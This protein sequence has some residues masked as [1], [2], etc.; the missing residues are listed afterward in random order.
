[1][2]SKQMK[3]EKKKRLKQKQKEITLKNKELRKNNVEVLSSDNDKNNLSDNNKDRMELLDLHK[4]ELPD[5]DDIVA[6]TGPRGYVL[7]ALNKMVYELNN[8]TISDEDIQGIA[9]LL[10]EL[11]EKPNTMYKQLLKIANIKDNDPR[12][13]SKT[14][15]KANLNMTERALLKNRMQGILMEYGGKGFNQSIDYSG[16]RLY[17]EM[18]YRLILA[19]LEEKKIRSIDLTVGY[20]DAIYE[21]GVNYMSDDSQHNINESRYIPVHFNSLD[22]LYNTYAIYKNKYKDFSESSLYSLATASDMAK[23]YESREEG[24]DI[25]S[26]NGIVLNYVGVLECELK[27]FMALKFNLKEID[28][29]LVDAINYLSKLNHPILSTQELIEDLHK[30]RKLRNKAAHGNFITYDEYSYVSNIISDF[31]LDQI[32]IELSYIKLGI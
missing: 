1:M 25:I 19:G 9:R 18:T 17:F 29:K 12:L 24:K 11:A 5:I 15:I 31:L 6:Y 10:I 13:K 28:L 21:L 8:K 16:I 20:G 23:Q 22:N 2:A 26:Y 7:K 4:E 32:S 3:K 14:K 27:K 30:V